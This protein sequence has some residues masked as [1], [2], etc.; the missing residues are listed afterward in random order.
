[1]ADDNLNLQQ[2]IERA[3]ELKNTFGAINDAVGSLNAALRVSS[4]DAAN[5]ANIFSQLGSSA[6]RVAQVQEQ[7][8]KSAKGT[9]SALK[10]QADNQNRARTLAAQAAI[11]YQKATTATGQTRDNLLRQSENLVRAASEAED[12]ARVYQQIAQEAAKLDSS[13]KFFS[14]AS[15]FISSIPGFSAFSAPFKEAEEAARK[16]VVKTGSTLAGFGAGLKSLGKSLFDLLSIPAL[17]AGTLQLSKSTKELSTNLGVSLAT[18]RNIVREFDSFALRTED[19]RITTQKLIEAQ[20]TL[21][22]QL[23]LSVQFSGETLK[24]FILLTEYIGVSTESAARLTMLSEGLGKNSREFTDNLAE[25][26]TVAGQALG[27]N[28]PLKEAFNTIG[29]LSATTLVNLQ[30]NPQAIAQAVVESKRLGLSFQE[31]QSTV[32]KLLNFEE[33][34]SSELEAELLTGRQLNLERARSAALRG[35]EVSLA[36][37]LRSQVGS[38]A[39]FEKLSVIQ[40]ESLAAAFGLNVEQMSEM[41]LKQEAIIANEKAARDLTSEQVAEAR[42]LATEKGIGFGEA[43]SQIQEQRD[44]A[45]AFEDASKKLL[46]TFQSLF[47]TLAPV[48]EKI[49]KIAGDL[50]ANPFFKGLTLVGAGTMA[51]YSIAKSLNLIPQ[52]VIVTNLPGG[53]EGG[54]GGLG[55]MLST[56]PG[57]GRYA[58]AMRANRMGKFGMSRA[59]GMKGVGIG[60]L[61]AVAGMGAEALSEQYEEGSAANVGFGV[62]GGALE[63]AGVGASIGSFVPGIGTLAGAGIGA[64]IGG[65]VAYLQKKDKQEE[66]GSKTSNEKY[67]QMI[68]LLQA[69]SQKDTKIFMDSNQVGIGLALGNPR[70]N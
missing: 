23:G 24:N 51:L 42:K 45:K 15:S 35:D 40:R 28:I 43:L 70:L 2:N 25:S 31:I 58:A 52:R 17:I 44:A 10:E 62:T 61:A 20:N 12:L 64:A 34:I 30:R 37:E 53:T 67:D 48:L 3:Q 41:L 14:T 38:L 32:N 18:S 7:A 6:D 21:T 39:Q 54:Q 19:S 57:G 11:A 8:Q 33:S 36:R 49:A 50:A 4:N 47:V 13:T 63:G 1:M 56:L 55:G 16:A 22:N 27:V 69:Q 68:K 26:V 60:A 5:V 9:A 59:M 65:L 46:G 29:K 66:E